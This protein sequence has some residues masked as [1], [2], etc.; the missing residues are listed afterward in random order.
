MHNSRSDFS[1]L[2]KFEAGPGNYDT[3]FSRQEAD[4]AQK[5][6][7]LPVTLGERI[8]RTETAGFAVTAVLEYLYGDFG[9]GNNAV[10]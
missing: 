9:V 7:F 2:T 5:A 3:G 4:I 10:N 1:N 6:G 8:L